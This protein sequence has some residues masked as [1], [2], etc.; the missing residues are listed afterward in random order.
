MPLYGR[1]DTE[2]GAVNPSFIKGIRSMLVVYVI[3][4]VVFG[5]NSMSSAEVIAQGEAECNILLLQVLLIPKYTTAT[6]AITDLSYSHTSGPTP[7]VASSAALMYVC[8]SKLR[9]VV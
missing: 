9:D 5:I 1:F 3:A 2:M 4:W 8:S 7:Q 6:H